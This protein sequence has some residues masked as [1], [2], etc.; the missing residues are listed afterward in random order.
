MLL[1][2]VHISISPEMLESSG[3]IT[4]LQRCFWALQKECTHEGLKGDCFPDSFVI[5]D[6]KFGNNVKI[7]LL[8]F[9]NEVFGPRCKTMQNHYG[10]M[11]KRHV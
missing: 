1:G 2:L 6:P 9:V 7:T 11:L 3:L 10:I 8:E 4:Y 5:V